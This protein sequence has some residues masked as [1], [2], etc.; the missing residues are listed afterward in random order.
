MSKKN[1]LCFFHQIIGGGESPSFS[2][3]GMFLNT[4]PNPKHSSTCPEDLPFFTL[5]PPV[6]LASF[7]CS[8][9]SFFFFSK[10]SP[11]FVSEFFKTSWR[12]LNP[13]LSLTHMTLVDKVHKDREREKE[14][15]ERAILM[16]RYS[17]CKCLGKNSL[18][19]HVASLLN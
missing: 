8:P 18:G 1:H 11:R 15:W 12:S 13:N 19:W 7:C 17:I 9:S 5:R 16:S 10:E 3:L 14:N 4:F 6:I 2:F